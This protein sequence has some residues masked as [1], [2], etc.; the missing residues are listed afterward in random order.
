M[1]S[2]HTSPT[3]R[4]LAVVLTLAGAGCNNDAVG[5]DESSSGAGS[6]SSGS[7]DDATSIQ[8]TGS[9]E[10]TGTGE[11]TGTVDTT[12]MVDPTT[13]PGESTG[14]TGSTGTTGVID[15][16]G[17]TGTGDTTDSSSSTG[18][19]EDPPE[20]FVKVQLVAFNDL[21]GNLEPPAGSSGRIT[22]P[23]NTQVDAGGVAFLATH[24]AALRADNPNTIVV[25]AGDL[26]GASP[27]VSAL[28]H[29]EPTIEVM[30]QIGLDFNAVGNH[31]FDDG[32]SELLRMQNGGCHPM[33]GCTDG[34]PFPGASFQFLAANVLVSE[35]PVKTLLPSYA[36]RELDGVRIAFIGMTLE[37]TPDIVTPTGIAGLTFVD[38]AERA[39][40]LVPE[41]Q[42]M[43]VEAIVVLIHEGGVQAGGY[44]DQCVG[45]SGA[46]VDIV[47]NLSDAIDVVVTGHTH[48]AYNCVI[49]DKVV[50]SAASFGR[51]LT[52]IDL[53][54]STLTGDVTAVTAKNVIVTRDVAEADIASFVTLY[55]DLAAP[56]ANKAIGTITATL[57]RYPPMMKPG[58]STMG[59]VIADSQLAATAP[60]MLGAAQIAFMNPGG[61]RADLLYPAA[62]NEPQDGIVSY[63]ETFAVQ[64]FGN[65]LVV[66]TLTGAQIDALLEQQFAEGKTPNILQVSKGF[67]FAYSVGAMIGAKVDPASIKLNGVPLVADQEYR[68]TVNSFLAA[69]GDGFSVLVAGTDRIGGA[70]DLDAL[71]DYFAE[72]SPVAPPALDRITELP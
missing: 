18:D 61:V 16:T 15:T 51:L 17:T 13:E 45:I 49:A 55:K 29:D 42:A 26:I 67:T 20:T 7:T 24:V 65:S 46:I 8:P 35:Q 6:T 54:I 52:D 34:T 71:A 19:T 57:D 68:V 40:A 60:V 47:N 28:F 22:L 66:M 27:L 53:E 62:P 39:N 63:G 5:A 21:H 3:C 59:A 23:D 38:E 36:I 58:L 12:G 50:T 70:N 43:G 64:P 11:P 37:G 72:Q 33:D 14:S 48:S 41:L 2:F 10:T 4:R 56:L 9:V 44:Y 69:G 1:H 30:N 31:E 32:S 25:S